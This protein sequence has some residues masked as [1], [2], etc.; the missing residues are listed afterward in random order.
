MIQ[1]D[2]VVLAEVLRS[3]GY[4]ACHEIVAGPRGLQEGLDIEEDFF[5][6]WEL[7]LPENQDALEQLDFAA[8]KSRRGPGWS[9]A[10][11][12]MGVGD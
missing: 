4:E 3:R 8:I 5:P 12:A 2:L 10:P 9:V 1:V 6:L 11:P 7:N